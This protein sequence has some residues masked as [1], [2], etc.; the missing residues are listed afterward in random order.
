MT[1]W[2]CR[3]CKKTCTFIRD[4]AP[5]FD[6]ERCIYNERGNDKKARWFIPVGGD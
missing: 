4:I 3:E 5:Y 2:V 6:P 1:V